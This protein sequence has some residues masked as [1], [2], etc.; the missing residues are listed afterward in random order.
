MFIYQLVKDQL[1]V[2][3]LWEFLPIFYS[4]HTIMV[5]WGLANLKR[6]IMN[7][8][9][10]PELPKR[11]QGFCDD[12]SKLFELVVFYQKDIKK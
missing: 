9:K 2:I 5:L 7:N 6:R 8:E 11:K 10:I 12:Y 4:N 1:K 3:S